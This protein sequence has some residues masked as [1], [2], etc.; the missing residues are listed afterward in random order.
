[1]A[2][3]VVA[4]SR[5]SASSSDP[6]APLAPDNQTNKDFESYRVWLREQVSRFKGFEPCGVKAIDGQCASVVRMME[7]E[8]RRLVALEALC[9]DREKVL[10][11][12]LSSY[13]LPGGG[14]PVV[15]PPRAYTTLLGGFG[16]D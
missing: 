12:P 8:Q 6:P 7:S 13:F 15:V 10:S 16:N 14:Q 9:W 5:Y 4:A 3:R 2:A 1:M 11:H